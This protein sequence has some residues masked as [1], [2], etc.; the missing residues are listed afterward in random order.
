[1]SKNALLSHI[2]DFTPVVLALLAALVF[3]RICEWGLLW[4]YSAEI[5]GFGY[6]DSQ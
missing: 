1:M 5:L 3:G 4:Y 6:R 2:L